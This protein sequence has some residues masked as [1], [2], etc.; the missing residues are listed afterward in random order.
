[1]PRPSAGR[2]QVAHH[3]AVESVAG[4]AD[5]VVAQDFVAGSAM[6]RR[7]T[8][9]KSQHREIA[10]AAAEVRDQYRLV[11]RDSKRVVV[12][13]RNRLVLEHHVGPSRAPNRDIKPATREGLVGIAGGCE[14]DRASDDDSRRQLAELRDRR[15]AERA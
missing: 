6:F 11:A 15:V 14:M 5:A 7:R 10:G 8:R 1:M 9:L 2:D 3:A 12:R 13:R 4:N